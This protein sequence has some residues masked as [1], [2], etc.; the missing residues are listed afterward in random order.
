MNTKLCRPILLKTKELSNLIKENITN[1]LKLSSF[2]NPLLWENQQLILISLDP[3]EKI[4]EDDL[5][6]FSKS[7]SIHKHLGS[8]SFNRLHYDVD[9][10]FKIMALQEQLPPE[11]IQQF[12]EEYNNRNVKDIEIEM[13]I[14]FEPYFKDT[15]IL[16]LKNGFVNIINNSKPQILYTEEE[17]KILLHK[18]DDEI[19]SFGRDGYYSSSFPE[20]TTEWFEQN[21]KK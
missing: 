16:N 13:R 14:I 1:K 9:K 4:R 19:G 2:N 5:Y 3:N 17:V 10:C 7:N 21:K 15:E 20:A 12:I 11:Y 6:Y 8:T 18:Y